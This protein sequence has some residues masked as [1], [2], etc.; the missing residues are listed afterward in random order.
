ML[1]WPVQH[2]R[3][4]PREYRYVYTSH[5]QSIARSASLFPLAY[6]SSRGRIK[7]VA[8][9][10]TSCS[11]IGQQRIKDKDCLTVF[12][13]VSIFSLRSSSSSLNPESTSVSSA[14]DSLVVWCFASIALSSSFNWFIYRHKF[15]ELIPSKQQT[16]NQ[17]PNSCH[18]GWMGWV[19]GGSFL[20]PLTKM[21]FR[22][23][24]YQSGSSQLQ[25]ANRRNVR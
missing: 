6:G 17:S 2:E 25:D 23:K 24:H 13:F 5:G 19:A 22:R 16:K 11:L 1:S 3:K 4:T 9:V 12:P 8:F 14:T 18:G 7:R 10:A 15:D 21:N 20:K